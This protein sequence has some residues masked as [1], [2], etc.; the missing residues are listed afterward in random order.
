MRKTRKGK[1]LIVLRYLGSTSIQKKNPRIVGGVGCHNTRWS[2]PTIYTTFTHTHTY[3]L[4]T[5]HMW[6]DGQIVFSRS[7]PLNSKRNKSDFAIM[8]TQNCR[9]D[10][11]KRRKPSWE[12]KKLRLWVVKANTQISKPIYIYI[13]RWGELWVADGMWGVNRSLII[14]EPRKESVPIGNHINFP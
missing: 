5:S 3:T 14:I 8:R 6:H 13:W 9:G 1:P 11:A 7:S 10:A 4:L 2:L 12:E